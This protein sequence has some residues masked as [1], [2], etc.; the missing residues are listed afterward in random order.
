[1][2]DQTPRIPVFSSDTPADGNV[3][4][5]DLHYFGCDSFDTYDYGTRTG[6]CDCRS[7]VAALLTAFREQVIAEHAVGTRPDCTE[8]K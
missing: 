3:G 4:L 5:A 2:S 7:T 1:M 8:E 6:D